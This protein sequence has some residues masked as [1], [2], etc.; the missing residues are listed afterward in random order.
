MNSHC[1]KT[2]LLCLLTFALLNGTA[3][4]LEAQETAL[5]R[6]VAEPDP[7]YEW[8]VVRTIRQPGLTTLVIDMKSQTWRNAKE[9]DRTLWQHWLIVAKPDKV[10]S[11]TGLLFISGGRNGGDPPA[12]PNNRIAKLAL[13]S[14]SVVATLMMVPNQPLEFHKDGRARNEDDLVAY[15]WIEYFKTGDPTWPAR[16]PMVKS[17]VRAMDTITAVMGSKEGGEIPVSKFVV[18]GG[19]KRGWTTWLTGAVDQ[20]VVAIVPIVIDVLNV[21]RSMRH[22]YAAYGFWAPS[23]GNYVEQKV[24]QY[25][26]SE[27]MSQLEQL[28]DPY[29]YRDRLAMPKFILNA[30]GDQFFLPDSSQF[31]FDGLRGDKYLCYV[32]NADHSLDGSDAVQSLL[33]FYLTVLRH[34]PRP[35]ITWSFETDGAIRVASHTAPKR[36]VLWQATNPKARDFRVETLGKKY[37][38]SVLQVQDDGSFRAQVLPPEKGWTAYFVELSFDLGEQVPFKLTTPVRVAPDTLPFQDK[39]PLSNAQ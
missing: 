12:G 16:N 7:S 21:E 30:S 14:Q 8:K 37:T 27:K 26:G 29:S 2:G 1:C 36:V 4:D 38:Q 33:A 10:S 6:Y 20:R 28:V 11:E 32:P 17:A 3:S 22:H 31:Y 15:T 24:F 25:L 9:V 5:D 23:V 13:A 34:K 18:A 35:E 39:D 19:S